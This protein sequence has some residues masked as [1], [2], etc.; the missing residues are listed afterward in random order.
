MQPKV[1]IIHKTEEAKEN[2]NENLHFV[3]KRF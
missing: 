1:L 2:V 3:S